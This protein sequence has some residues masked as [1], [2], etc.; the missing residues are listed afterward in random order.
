MG[1]IPDAVA[2]RCIRRT[3]SGPRFKFIVLLAAV[4]ALTDVLVVDCIPAG[5]LDYCAG[6]VV[7]IKVGKEVVGIE[8]R[9]GDTMYLGNESVNYQ[10]SSSMVAY[11]HC[12]GQIG[13]DEVLQVQ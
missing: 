12:I 1:V 5:L 4:V 11:N 9:A 7:G 3:G 13:H 8:E 2:R 10:R 6:S